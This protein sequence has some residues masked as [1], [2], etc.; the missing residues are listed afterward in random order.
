MAYLQIRTIIRA[1]ELHLCDRYIITGQTVPD[2]SPNIVIID[3]TIKEAMQCN[4]S[5]QSQSSQHHHRETKEKK[6][7]Q[8]EYGD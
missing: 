5:Q 8:Y 6:K 4:N 3:K 7:S 1:A 2:S